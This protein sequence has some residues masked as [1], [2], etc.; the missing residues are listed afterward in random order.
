M[1]II[2][3]VMSYS[4]MVTNLVKVLDSQIQHCYGLLPLNANLFFCNSEAN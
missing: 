3:L 1:L 2:A 4:Q